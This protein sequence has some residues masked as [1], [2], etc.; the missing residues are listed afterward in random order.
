MRYSNGFSI[1]WRNPA[2]PASV[3]SKRAD[4]TDV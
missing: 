3:P 4:D 1:G 2:V